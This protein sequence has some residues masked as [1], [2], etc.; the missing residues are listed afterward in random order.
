ME[1]KNGM[2]TL[3]PL[4][5]R[6]FRFYEDVLHQLRRDYRY[7]PVVVFEPRDLPLEMQ[8]KTVRIYRRSDEGR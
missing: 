4:G 1:V 7:D 2:R 5:E 6:E 8:G 3:G